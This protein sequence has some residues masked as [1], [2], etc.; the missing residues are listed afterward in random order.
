MNPTTSR[1]LNFSFRTRCALAAIAVATV[2]TPRALGSVF[3]DEEVSG[4]AKETFNGGTL[5]K[6]SQT[7]LNSL[8]E[9]DVM[10]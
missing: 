8:T 3:F 10:V 6:A 1:A 9:L 4:S 7:Y 2:L 5:L